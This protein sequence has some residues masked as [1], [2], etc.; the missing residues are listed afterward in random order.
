MDLNARKRVQVFQCR[1]LIPQLSI[2]V[3]KEII[4]EKTE[5]VL[6]LNG[7]IILVCS[8]L[9]RLLSYSGLKSCDIV[10]D[11]NK[12]LQKIPHFSHS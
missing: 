7:L 4:F 5:I 1:E 10:D 2:K 11:D 12:Q 6:S 8:V 9:E 3:P